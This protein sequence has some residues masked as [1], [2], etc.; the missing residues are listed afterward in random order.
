MPVTVVDGLPWIPPPHIQI[1]ISSR[2]YRWWETWGALRSRPGKRF[3]CSNVTTVWPPSGR[4]GVGQGN[5]LAFRGTVPR[6]LSSRRL[7]KWEDLHVIPAEVARAIGMTTARLRSVI[8]GI[9]FSLVG[10]AVR[11]MWPE[12]PLVRDGRGSLCTREWLLS[13]HRRSCGGCSLKNR[14]APT[15]GPGRRW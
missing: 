6:P 12:M 15:Y 7:P 4:P 11:W 10:V 9:P 1:R 2:D 5:P 8:M 3:F 14:T 13:S